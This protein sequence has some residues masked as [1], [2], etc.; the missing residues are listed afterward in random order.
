MLSASLAA[1]TTISGAS[2]VETLQIDD[3]EQ[4]IYG[5]HTDM[6]ESRSVTVRVFL[7]VPTRSG[8]LRDLEGETLLA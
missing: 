3:N 6:G 8:C 4:P 1:A 5:V 2:A 7:E